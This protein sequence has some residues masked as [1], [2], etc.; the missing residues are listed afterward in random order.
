MSDK[1][2]PTMTRKEAS[3]H[4]STAG[5]KAMKEAEA[6][7]APDVA[8]EALMDNEPLVVG[9][10]TLRTLSLPVM[11]ALESVGSAYMAEMSSAPARVEMRDVVLAIACFTDPVAMQRLGRRKDQEA[12]EARAMEICDGLG[13]EEMV[14]INAWINGQFARV[15]ALS[16]DGQQDDLQLGDGEKKPLAG[17]PPL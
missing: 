7:G 9:G 4:I 17:T 6:Q 1:K 3:F 5:A 13:T 15:A 12:I 8:V 11:W 10:I 14:K 16:D 2:K